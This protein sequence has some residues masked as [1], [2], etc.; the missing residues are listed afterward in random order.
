MQEECGNPCAAPCHKCWKPSEEHPGHLCV[1]LGSSFLT[2]PTPQ[3]EVNCITTTSIDR[4]MLL[5][6]SVE[7]AEN[8]APGMANNLLAEALMVRSRSLL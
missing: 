8:L 4:L 6:V 3:L 2:Q 7:A 1:N 5:P